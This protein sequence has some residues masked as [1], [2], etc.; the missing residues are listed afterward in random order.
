MNLGQAVAVCLYELS[1]GALDLPAAPPRAP[2]PAKAADTE[3]ITRLLLD[4]LG[5]SGYVNPV[6]SFEIK[7]PF[8]RHGHYHAVLEVIVNGH[9]ANTD[10]FH[11]SCTSI[12]GAIEK[13]LKEGMTA[14]K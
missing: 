6:T 2:K 1:R 4:V 3:Q 12:K 11:S 8:D 10:D 7:G 5:K 13:A 14:P 9:S